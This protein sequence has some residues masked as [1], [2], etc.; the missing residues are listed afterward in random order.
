MAA[1]V[2]RHAREQ[3]R[4]E[5]AEVIGCLLAELFLPKRFSCLAEGADLA[6]RLAAARSV[7]DE[8]PH[9]LPGERAH[10]L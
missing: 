1:A 9:L 4:D 10:I 2:A 5:D 3:Q 8:E 7:L 6:A